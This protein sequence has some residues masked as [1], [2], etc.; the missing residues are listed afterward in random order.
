MRWE[1]GDVTLPLSAKS[2]LGR[3]A[4]HP[5]DVLQV[6]PQLKSEM[7]EHPLLADRLTQDR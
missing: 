3:R 4:G 2:A 7:M 1:E 6:R 5:A